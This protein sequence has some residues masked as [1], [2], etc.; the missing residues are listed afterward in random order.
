MMIVALLQPILKWPF[1]AA[2]QRAE[3]PIHMVSRGVGV[4]GFGIDP[5]CVKY[6]GEFEDLRGH[7]Y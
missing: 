4:L 2:L 1:I 6:T 3:Y 5:D 7:K